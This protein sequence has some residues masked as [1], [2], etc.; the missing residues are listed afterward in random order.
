MGDAGCVSSIAYPKKSND[1][2]CP[3][4]TAY[5][6]V[7]RPNISTHGI[8]WLC[9]LSD[10]KQNLIY[11]LHI[12]SICDRFMFGNRMV[13]SPKC[14][15]N[16]RSWQLLTCGVEYDMIRLALICCPGIDPYIYRRHWLQEFPFHFLINEPL[17]QE[18][19]LLQRLQIL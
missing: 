18:S 11:N 3:I 6:V 14:L 13:F 2:G 16:G 7:G 10:V 1:M 9:R 8:V 19:S 4:R 5:A 15:Y 17:S 12:I